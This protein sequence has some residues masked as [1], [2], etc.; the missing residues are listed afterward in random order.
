V[1]G[2]GHNERIE[3]PGDAIAFWAPA[4]DRGGGLMLTWEEVRGE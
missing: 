4:D 3:V 1:R 2:T